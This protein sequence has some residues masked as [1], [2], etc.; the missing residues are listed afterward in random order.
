MFKDQ[1]AKLVT[2]GLTEKEASVYMAL[3]NIGHGTADQVSKTTTL[4]RSTTYVQ[5]KSLMEMGLVTTFKIGKKTFFAAES[6][7]HIERILDRRFDQLEHLQSEAKQLLP[8]LLKLFTSTGTRPVVRIFAGKEGLVSMRNEMLELAT[9]QILIVNSYDQMR[10]LFTYDELLDFTERREKKKILARAIYYKSE[11]KDFTPFEYQR[12]CRV[13][14]ERLPFGADLYI[15]DDYVSFASTDNTVVGM[16]IS[17]RDIA[18]T[19]RALFEALWS[20]FVK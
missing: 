4:N 8:Q 1:E 5:I 6:P 19:L 11:G 2:F 20:Q 14:K 7:T 17:S 18:N 3:L 12:F 15:Y 10:K 16:T 9:K 13:T